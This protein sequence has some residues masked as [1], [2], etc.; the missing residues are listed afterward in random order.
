MRGIFK[1]LRII[2]EHLVR[3]LKL[4][5]LYPFQKPELPERSRGLIQLTVEEET[6]TIKCEACRLCEKACPPRA[7]TMNYEQRDAFRPFRRRPA[8]RAKTISG[9]YRPRM[10]AA[11]EYEG[12]RPLSKVVDI[13]RV[14]VSA[15]CRPGKRLARRNPRLPARGRGVDAACWRTCSRPLA[16]CLAG[17]WRRWPW[18]RAYR[19]ATCTVWRR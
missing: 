7:I 5:Q 17:R 11:C 4:T 18:R 2:G 13:P 15:G 1:G 16:I 14:E 10:V 3:F 12:I 19:S 9:F 6:G 8:F